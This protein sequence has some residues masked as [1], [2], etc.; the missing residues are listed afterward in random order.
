MPEIE[1]RKTSGMTEFTVHD[2]KNSCEELSNLTYD[3][4]MAVCELLAY[5]SKGSDKEL[6]CRLESVQDRIDSLASDLDDMSDELRTFKSE[7]N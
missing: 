7:L 4:A 5:V 2:V 1:P 3:Q 6:I